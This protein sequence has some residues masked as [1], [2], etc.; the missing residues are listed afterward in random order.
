MPK[1]KLAN[2]CTNFSGTL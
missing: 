1:R 2:H